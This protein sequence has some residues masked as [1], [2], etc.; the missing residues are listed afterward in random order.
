MDS[1]PNWLKFHIGINRYELYSRDSPAVDALLRDLGT[2][3]ITS[4]GRCLAG[5]A[6]GTRLAGG[7]GPCPRWSLPA[8]HRQA[9]GRRQVGQAGCR[10]GT[11][12]QPSP[13]RGCSVPTIRDTSGLRPSLHVGSR[14]QPALPGVGGSPA[15]QCPDLPYG[16]QPGLRRAGAALSTLVGGQPPRAPGDL[17]NRQTGQP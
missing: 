1:Y 11:C 13:S 5:R 12:P 10:G 15:E 8:W 9:R 3:R 2:Q 6:V 17:L 4:V 7:G 16:G 14:D